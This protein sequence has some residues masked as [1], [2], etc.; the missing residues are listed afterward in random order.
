MTKQ[1]PDFYLYFACYRPNPTARFKVLDVYGFTEDHVFNCSRDLLK[2]SRNIAYLA[3]SFPSHR[4]RNRL[5]RSSCSINPR[6]QPTSK[7][8]RSSGLI[9]LRALPTS[10]LHVS[11]SHR[12][13]GSTDLQ[14][15]PI[16]RLP[17]HRLYRPTSFTN[18]SSGSVDLRALLTYRLYLPTSSTNRSSGSVDLRALLAFGLY[19]PLGFTYPQ[20]TEPQDLLTFRLY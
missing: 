17:T 10:K 4:N 13:S 2:P 3:T 20:A 1:L 11:S 18:R 15:L 19:R 16:P 14:A 5:Y 12:P 6:A 8:Y 7:L 9:D